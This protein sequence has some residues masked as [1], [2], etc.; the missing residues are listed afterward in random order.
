MRDARTPSRRSQLKEV[1]N[2]SSMEP[3]CTSNLLKISLFSSSSPVSIYNSTRNR[4]LRAKEKPR[5]ATLLPLVGKLPIDTQLSPSG[6]NLL[7]GNA[8]YLPI[9]SSS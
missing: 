6:Q 3:L 5:V 8:S 1:P 2:S 9:F 7:I 4:F